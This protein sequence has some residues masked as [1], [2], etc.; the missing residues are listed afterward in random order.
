MPSPEMKSDHSEM[1]HYKTSEQ[2]EQRHYKPPENTDPMQRV[3]N[4]KFLTCQQQHWTLEV[5]EVT[6]KFEGK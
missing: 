1:H 4:C 2:R 5:K 6:Q 3:R